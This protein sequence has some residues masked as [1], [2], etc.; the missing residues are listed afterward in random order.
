MSVFLDTGILVAYANADDPRHRDATA[1]VEDVLSGRHGDAF[2][3]DYVLAEAFNFVRQRVKSAAVASALD[4]D[5]FGRAGTRPIVR[6][7]L[8]VHGT[9]FASARAQYLAR[10]K[11]GLSFTDWTTVELAR[12]HKIGVVA[13]FDRAFSAWADVIPAAPSSRR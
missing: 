5:V 7:V 2:T 6:D 10:W 3:S 1:V 8:R 11:A 13:T 12:Q 9:V 4:G